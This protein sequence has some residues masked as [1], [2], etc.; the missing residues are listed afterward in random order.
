MDDSDLLRG[1]LSNVISPA[2]R[3]TRIIVLQIPLYRG[4]H[5]RALQST[6]KGREKKVTREK[7]NFLNLKIGVHCKKTY[8]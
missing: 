3:I 2:L 7:R 5:V 1:I 8:K 4:L 6:S